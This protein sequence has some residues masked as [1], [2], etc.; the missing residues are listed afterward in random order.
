[1]ELFGIGIG[2]WISIIAYVIAFIVGYIKLSDKVSN[3][4]ENFKQHKIDINH[5]IQCQSAKTQKIYQ[6]LASIR[7]TIYAIS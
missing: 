5:K 2:N 3:M 6:E 4:Q 1:M 7:E